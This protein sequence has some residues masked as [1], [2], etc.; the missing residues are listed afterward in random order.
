MSKRVFSRIDAREKMNHDLFY[1]FDFFDP[2]F[3]IE[4]DFFETYQSNLWTKNNERLSL[5]TVILKHILKGDLRVY[6]PYD[7]TAEGMKDIIRDGY[8]LKY[9]VISSMGEKSS[10]DGIDALFLDQ[11]YQKAALT[12]LAS[13]SLGQTVQLEDEF[14]RFFTVEK[15]NMSAKDALANKGSVKVVELGGTEMTLEN[16]ILQGPDTEVLWLSY[17]E[18]FEKA[19]A[20]SKVG[21]NI[22]TP[23]EIRLLASQD[24]VAYN[25]KED[26]FFDKERSILDKRIIAIAPVANYKY[27]KAKPTEA[28]ED[29]ILFHDRQGNLNTVSGKY[30]GSTFQTEMFWLYFPQ[31]R[32]VMVNYFTYNDRSDAQ[33]TSFDDLFWK[34]KFKSQIYKTSDK[35]DRDIQDYR[36]GVDALYEAE[37]VKG[38]IRKW[39]H[40]VWNY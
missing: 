1:P 24:I 27:N 19:W 15:L 26:W 28:K 6:A 34:R 23:P 9:P 33:W 16:F 38:E 29:N 22:E 35:F 8:Q 20:Y 14:G 7:V 39:E 40:D 21:E 36:F 32:D 11:D 37:K 13:Y 30:D 31:L 18:K 2:E 25:I 12:R 4:K 10:K 3:K 5:W 17:I